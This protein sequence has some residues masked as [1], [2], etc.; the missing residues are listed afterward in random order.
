[1]EVIVLAEKVVGG[2]SEILFDVDEWESKSS[3]MRF[4]AS[5]LGV[6]VTYLPGGGNGLGK[7][8]CGGYG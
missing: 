3:A 8:H 6:L 7:R 2:L 4:D 1:M 5:N